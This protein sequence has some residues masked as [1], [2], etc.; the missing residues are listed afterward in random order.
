MAGGAGEFGPF[1]EAEALDPEEI[2][3][4]SLGKDELAPQV[5][6]DPR[7]GEEVLEL[8]GGGHAD[9]AKA[10]PGTP[11]SKS[12]GGTEGLGIQAFPPG[13]VR[14]REAG[15]G[16]GLPLPMEGQSAETAVSGRSGQVDGGFVEVEGG[17]ARGGR[18][19]VQGA[20]A[21]GLDA[22]ERI[23]LEGDIGVPAEGFD[24]VETGRDA[25]VEELQAED[26]ALEGD[27]QRFPG[28]AVGGPKPVAGEVF[29]GEGLFTEEALDPLEDGQ[30]GGL[31]PGRQERDEF[32]AHAIAHELEV[33]VGAILPPGE[34]EIAGGGRQAR[35]GDPEERPD[36]P[37][38]GVGG[39]RSA[40][41]HAGEARGGG[42][43]E[44]AEEEEFR[45][46]IG[47]MGGGDA[48]GAEGAGGAGEEGVA[49]AA[50]GGLGGFA[51]G[52]LAADVGGAGDEA[53]AELSGGLGNALFIGIG[54]GA[55]ELVM[56]MGGDEGGSVPGAEVGEDPEQEHGIEAT[57]DGDDRGP[58]GGEQVGGGERV[59]DL[60]E[61]GVHRRGRLARPAGGS[62]ENQV[63]HASGDPRWG[64]RGRE[65][66]CRGAPHR[67]LAGTFRGRAAGVPAIEIFLA[68][69]RGAVLDGRGM[70]DVLLSIGI[71]TRNRAGYLGELLAALEAQVRESGVGE[72]ELEIQVSDNASTDGTGELGAAVAARLPHLR[73]SRNPAN[74]GPQGNYHKLVETARGRYRWIL[75]DDDIVLP[76]ALV[77]TLEVLRGDPGLGLIVHFET[78][79]DP[80]LTRP[81]RFGSYR[82]YIAECARVH[83][84]AL[85]EHTLT[86]SNVYRADVMDLGF[87]R[88]HD[89]TFFPH[90]YGMGEGL[91]RRGGAVFVSAHPAIRVRD[92]R[93]PAVDGVWPPGMEQNWLAYLGWLRECHE[94]PELQP[95]AAID[96]LR[97]E[98]LRKIT[99]HPL[100]YL[101]D[102]LPALRQPQAWWWFLKRIV[103]HS[104]RR[105]T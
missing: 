99:R 90:M 40:E 26:V 4:G 101:R 5:G 1:P 7:M 54:L 83:P 48:V 85:V 18:K 21:I 42:T 96:H 95:S 80:R 58:A 71:P 102:N 88:R 36:H 82:E 105:S 94:V 97:R 8:G 3:V 84:H 72:D 57:G 92:Q 76:G 79:Y 23:D 39:G 12:D 33:E 91:K 6:G 38:A 64:D 22:A 70:G 77:H 86:T 66:P 78:R 50:G 30:Q 41:G 49:K 15:V 31:E 46:V 53:D 87:A 81:Q 37:Q 98:L 55:A 56:E 104:R 11:V 32:V 73:Y 25:S 59:F 74:L 9:R 28:V 93:A 65:V 69:R 52:G 75:G 100:R 35:T 20:V 29:D 89:A 63:W 60:G 44:E 10:I 14:C 2:A 16:A 13:V 61:E 62:N 34:I 27:G 17:E 45:L 24:E 67:E 47:V 43:A 51:G 19:G 68:V 103:F